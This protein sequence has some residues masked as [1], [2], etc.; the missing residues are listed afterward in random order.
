MTLRRHFHVHLDDVRREG[1]YRIFHGSGATCPPGRPMHAG[2][3]ATTAAKSWYS[4][5]TTTL[6]WDVIRLSSTP[7]SRPRAKWAP[8][9]VVPEHLRQ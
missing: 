7:W 6:G 2:V 4:A 1:R 8:V 9:P 3:M 5:P